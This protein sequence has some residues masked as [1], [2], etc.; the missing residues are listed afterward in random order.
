M[1]RKRTS[2]MRSLAPEGA[3]RATGGANDEAGVDRG[4]YSARRKAEAVLRLFR[5]EDL[6]TLSRELGVTA[7]TLSRW[8]E[9]F[10]AGG[11][12]ALK[13]RQAE[14]VAEEVDR[15]RAKIGELTMDNELLYRKIHLLEEGRPFAPRR[16]R[17]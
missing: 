6:D 17:R 11:Q 16:S 4:R 7:G 10:L 3:R 8:Q 12:S 15:L 13:S 2:R 5:G 9:E 1:G 14:V